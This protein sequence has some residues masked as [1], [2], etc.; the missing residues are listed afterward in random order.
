MENV[1]F[2]GPING[3]ANRKGS[4][5]IKLAT[6]NLGFFTKWRIRQKEEDFYDLRDS[7]LEDLKDYD[8]DYNEVKNKIFEARKLLKK[9]EN[10]TFFK[11]KD[12]DDKSYKDSY[13]DLMDQLNYMEERVDLEHCI[14]LL[15]DSNEFNQADQ[16]TLTLGNLYNRGTD[17]TGQNDNAYENVK[18]QSK[19]F[20]ENSA[21]NI[22]DMLANPEIAKR[23]TDENAKKKLESQV[24]AITNAKYITTEFEKLKNAEKNNS[25]TLEDVEKF[26]ND[27]NSLGTTGIKKFLDIHTEVVNMLKNLSNEKN[28]AENAAIDTL[29][30]EYEKVKENPTIEAIDKFLANNQALGNLCPELAEEANQLKATLQQENSEKKDSFQ[31]PANMSTSTKDSKENEQEIWNSFVEDVKN[32]GITSEKEEE[33]RRQLSPEFYQSHKDEIKKM[34]I[35]Q[36]RK[37]KEEKAEASYQFLL[38]KQKNSKLSQQDIDDFKKLYL[39][40]DFYEKY[41]DGI[42]N[43]EQSLKPP[44]ENKEQ[45]PKAQTEKD[46][47]QSNG[48]ETFF[49]DYIKFL[50]NYR[51]AVD[52]G[53]QFSENM[54]ETFHKNCDYQ[55]KTI[56]DALK[57]GWITKEEKSQFQENVEKIRSNISE[58]TLRKSLDEFKRLANISNYSVDSKLNDFESNFSKEKEKLDVTN[59]ID[60]AQNAFHNQGKKAEVKPEPVVHS[61]SGTYEKKPEIKTESDMY[62]VNDLYRRLQEI[63]AY[64]KPGMN[65]EDKEVAEEKLSGLERRLQNLIAQK[66]INENTEQT[67]RNRIGETK[68]SINQYGK[69]YMKD[70]YVERCY[71][72]MDNL[73]GEWN[74]LENEIQALK[75]YPDKDNSFRLFELQ[76]RLNQVIKE[77]E[78]IQKKIDDYYRRKEEKQYYENSPIVDYNEQYSSEEKHKKGFSAGLKQ[79]GKQGTKERRQEE[80]TE[81]YEHERSAL[82][83]IMAQLATADAKT[84]EES[85]ATRKKIYEH[86]K[87]FL[88]K[89]Q[90]AVLE[91]TMNAIENMLAPM[92]PKQAEE[93]QSILSDYGPLGYWNSKEFEQDENT[94]TKTR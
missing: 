7:I 35:D 81:Y 1:T 79:L 22:R 63:D 25:L 19:E 54:L 62:F 90:K 92:K 2:K 20:A 71:S 73:D 60:Q 15:G 65:R 83:N 69:I 76:N 50:K 18:V 16:M 58:Q 24:D 30:A 74:K 64:V 36:N 11:L 27:F 68:A 17:K 9:L 80:A 85:L 94:N 33:L 34:I 77:R 39:N 48:R 32:N 13:D 66:E 28:V 88:S 82:I 55:I 47:T 21:K 41:K 37:R 59:M 56:D 40:E 89:E 75:N 10:P 78:F 23:I 43:M 67:V 42:S 29:K 49:A 38:E 44:V 87:T 46:Q 70:S 6:E 93:T 8:Y 45:A 51:P 5:P 26:R 86:N 14:D 53:N 4:K 91:G 72:Q 12:V 3:R 61:T 57:N 31:S 52:N 84:I